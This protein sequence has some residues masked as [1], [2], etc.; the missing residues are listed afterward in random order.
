MSCV[1]ITCIFP[2]KWAN[3]TRPKMAMSMANAVSPMKVLVD[4]D[5]P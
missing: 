4:K 3:K 2:I 1:H 5:W